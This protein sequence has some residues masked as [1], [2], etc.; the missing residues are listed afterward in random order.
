MDGLTHFLQI[1]QE[2][3]SKVTTWKALDEAVQKT[4]KSTIPTLPP[5]QPPSPSESA[6]EQLPLETKRAGF[7]VAWQ[8]TI[9]E[10]KDSEF[11]KS[12]KIS[13][14][15]D[16]ETILNYQKQFKFDGQNVLLED[17]EL[18]HTFAANFNDSIIDEIYNWS[19]KYEWKRPVSNSNG[20]EY[21]FENLAMVKYVTSLYDLCNVTNA[22]TFLSMGNDANDSFQA[23]LRQKI[24]VQGISIDEI[25]SCFAQYKFSTLKSGEY[26]RVAELELQ[27]VPFHGNEEISTRFKNG[28]LGFFQVTDRDYLVGNPVFWN[29]YSPQALQTAITNFSKDTDL[30]IV[31][32]IGQSMIEQTQEAKVFKTALLN[33]VRKE[34]YGDLDFED[35]EKLAILN[36]ATTNRLWTRKE[37][38]FE[39][40]TLKSLNLDA[41]FKANADNL[42][43]NEET[44]E[45]KTACANLHFLS[46]VLHIRLKKVDQPGKNVLTELK[47][48]VSENKFDEN[49][50]KYIGNI[51][52]SVLKIAILYNYLWANQGSPTNEIYSTYQQKI[53]DLTSGELEFLLSTNVDKS[54]SVR[55]RVNSGVLFLTKFDDFFKKYGR[56]AT[57]ERTSENRQ[58]LE[59]ELTKFK[60]YI[61]G[62]KISTDVVRN[63]TK[64]ISRDDITLDQQVK[65]MCENKNIE[66]CIKN[67]LKLHE[68]IAKYPEALQ[69]Q[70][71]FAKL[72]KFLQC[73]A[74]NFNRENINAEPYKTALEGLNGNEYKTYTSLV[75][76]CLPKVKG[77]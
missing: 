3:Q 50:F 30:G 58:Q 18:E 4:S 27:E 73:Y 74:Q 8:K 65:A 7:L 77:D 35:L 53:L 15:S 76:G 36:P 64:N 9:N 25:C 31:Y 29:I 44:I 17:I 14:P 5:P 61:I 23:C 6:W 62:N 38:E 56:D 37:M 12:L 75:K 46:T 70:T 63:S 24:A 22:E 52:D 43:N 11:F 68:T 71:L 34:S 1:L 33:V 55:K 40:Q 26:K 28:T 2:A 49:E 72:I 51:T 16:A 67:I 42:L 57:L 66:I 39:V 19:K 69:K 13:Q 20:K 59:A 54:E 47:S 21:N 10:M 60:N 41:Q 48:Y 32:L 45:F